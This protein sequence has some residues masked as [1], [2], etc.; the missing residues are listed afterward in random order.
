MTCF[1]IQL[2]VLM[3]LWMHPAP[4]QSNTNEIPLRQADH[5]FDIEGLALPSD[6][7]V[8]NKRLYIVDGGDHSIVVTDLDGNH[9]FKFGNPEEG[10]PLRGPV[11]ITAD[12]RGRIYVCDS[13]NGRL[14]QYD[15]KG[16]LLLDIAIV[17]S[18]GEVARPIDVLVKESK[19]QI[20]VSDGTNH[21]I[22]TY[23]MAGEYLS[24]WGTRGRA[25]SEFR[26]PA[27][28]DMDAKGNIYVVDILNT[29]V[30]KFNRSGRWK[31][32]IGTWGVLPGRLFRPKGV[33]LGNR[34]QVF[35]TDSF[36]D[37][38]QVFKGDRFLYVLGDE[39]GNIRRF[40]SPGGIFIHQDRLY[41]TEMFDR[42]I[43]VYQLR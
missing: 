12:S 29:R 7:V 33:A 19:R 21:K 11:G 27:T 40:G 22:I 37:V 17:D 35:I 43:G 25:N 2:L 6:L 30:Q 15:S 36:M 18:H 20:Y 3:V 38:I 24:E 16:T 8:A 14:L 42:K 9:L 39:N 10:T 34:R 13:G 5:L 23:S 41:V 26:Y 28:M 4:V 1:F 31:T 32:N